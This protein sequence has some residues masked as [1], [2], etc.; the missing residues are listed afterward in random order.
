MGWLWLIVIGGAAFVALWR[1]GVSRGLATFVGTALAL[2]AAG[3]AWQQHAG[4]AGHPVKADAE[5][6]EVDPGLV[7]FRSAIMPGNEAVLAAAD[8]K[9]RVG[10]STGAAQIILDAIAREPD[11]APLWAGLGGAIVGHDGGQVSPAA[12]I[13]FRRAVALAP[14]APGPPF[15]LGLA[16]IQAGDLDSAKVAWVRTLALAPKEAPYRIE[17]AERLVMIDQFKAMKAG[18][19]AQRQRQ[20][21]G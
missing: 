16:Y 12:L 1:A 21:G 14:T 9:L 17:I 8:E 6:I 2:G 5:A 13:A 11:A 4:L 10:D 20:T 15:M 7:E 19:A 18:E 3:Y